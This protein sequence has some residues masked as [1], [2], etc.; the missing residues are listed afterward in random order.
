[1]KEG[2]ATKFLKQMQALAN[3]KKS[4]HNLMNK[5]TKLVELPNGSYL[6]KNYKKGCI[7]NFF[8]N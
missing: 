8:L 4:S 6:C 2:Y 5:W 7:A 1:M 3:G